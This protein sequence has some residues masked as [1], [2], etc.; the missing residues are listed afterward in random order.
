MPRAAALAL[1]RL[2]DLSTLLQTAEGF[3][4]LLAALRRGAAASSTA[5]GVRPP[6]WSAA[7]LGPARAAH[8]ARRHR[9]PAR[10]RRLGR[11]PV[12]LLR[13]PPRRLPRLGQPAGGRPAVDEIAGQR[14]RLLKQLEAGEPPRLLLTTIQALIQPVPDR[15]EFAASRRVLRVGETVRPRRAGR[16]AGRARLPARRGGRA[17]RRVQ[18]PRR[19]PRRLLARRRGAVSPRVLRRR[20]RVDP[21]V[22]AADAAQPRR[23]ADGGTDRPRPT[24]DARDGTRH[25]GGHLCDYL[26]AGRLDRPGRAGRPARAGQALPRARRRPARPVHRAGRLPAAAALSRASRCRRCPARRSRRPVI[27]ASNRSSASAATSAGCAT[28]WTP[29]PPATAC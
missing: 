28:S 15:A 19:H 17:A 13:R 25:D 9:P 12:Q 23:P 7:A 8:A 24:Q 1:D 18:P 21:P 5:P 2:T 20:D 16:L 6:A 26:P 3:E 14:L 4:P 22:L 11:R 29:W 27:C 10:P